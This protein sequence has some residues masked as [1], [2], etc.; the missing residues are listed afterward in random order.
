MTFSVTYFI[1]NEAGL[2]QNWNTV[3]VVNTYSYLPLKAIAIEEFPMISL[4]G[5]FPT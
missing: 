2:N 5:S 4:L 1:S 3:R